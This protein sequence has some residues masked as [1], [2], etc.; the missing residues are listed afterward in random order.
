MQPQQFKWGG[1]VCEKAHARARVCVC[2]SELKECKLWKQVLHGVECRPSRSAAVDD[3]RPWRKSGPMFRRLISKWRYSRSSPT[4]TSC[5]SAILLCVCVCVYVCVYV[6]VCVRVR[7]RVCREDAL[8][9]KGSMSW[10]TS[11]TLSVLE[12]G[13]LVRE[14]VDHLT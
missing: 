1:R 13:I 10:Q 9:C 3:T 8:K 5:R 12:H 11:L 2:V 6:C 14:V 7:V 4:C